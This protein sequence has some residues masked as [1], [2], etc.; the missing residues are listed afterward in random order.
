MPSSKADWYARRTWPRISDSPTTIESIPAATRNRCLDRGIV[1]IRVQMIG[2]VLGSYVTELREEVPKILGACVELRDDRVDLDAVARRED[3]SL[4]HV[5][6]VLQLVQRLGEL[7]V[8]DGEPL[9]QRDGSGLVI[10]A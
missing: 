3:R 6:G 9:Q 10:E 1:V 8:A 2:E 5:L 7:L 4:E